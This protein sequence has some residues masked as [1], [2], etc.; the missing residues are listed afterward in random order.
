MFEGYFFFVCIS[1]PSARVI[2]PF[3]T[4]SVGTSE[5]VSPFIAASSV[6]T[7]ESGRLR[8]R[9]RP[10]QSSPFRLSLVSSVHFACCPC[11]ACSFVLQ[12]F[13]CCFGSLLP[14][15][16]PVR[17]QPSLLA[18][19]RRDLP[20]SLLP[21]PSLSL[22]LSCCCLVGSKSCIHLLVF[23]FGRCLSLPLKL[24]PPNVARVFPCSSW[25]VHACLRGWGGVGWGGVVVGGLGGGLDGIRT[26]TT[27][28]YLPIVDC[29]CPYDL[30]RCPEVLLLVVPFQMLLSVASRCWSEPSLDHC[31]AFPSLAFVSCSY[32]RFVPWCGM[33]RPRCLV[34]GEGT[35]GCRAQLF[36]CVSF[37]VHIYITAITFGL[38]NPL[39]YCSVTVGCCGAGV[40]EMDA[41]IAPIYYSGLRHA[42]GKHVLPTRQ[43]HI[44]ACYASTLKLNHQI[45]PA[46]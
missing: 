14:R 33:C 21:C 10:V 20:L 7:S 34:A 28:L 32:G 4:P 2:L 39:Y 46:N 15:F 17:R 41:V 38:I 37:G 26:V 24:L 11:C 5:C 25:L 8:P 6:R 31:L 30:A 43:C 9:L 16:G 42:G 12:V 1:R 19:P 36:R 29:G 13:C 22:S 44:Y 40:D 23:A 45:R 18:G 35:G 27:I 3:L